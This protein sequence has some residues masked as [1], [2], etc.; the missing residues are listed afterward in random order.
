MNLDFRRFLEMGGRYIELNDPI[1]SY[2]KL[3]KASEEAL[4]RLAEYFN[5]A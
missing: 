1:Q 5:L 2:E 3:Y 4:K